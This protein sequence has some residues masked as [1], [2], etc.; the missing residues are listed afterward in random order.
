M[1]SLS[2]SQDIS[3][4]CAAPS[5][6]S[7]VRPPCDNEQVR[8]PHDTSDCSGTFRQRPIMRSAKRFLQ[9]RTAHFPIPSRPDKVRT[10]ST[11]RQ[12]ACGSNCADQDL[13]LVLTLSPNRASANLD[14]ARRTAPRPHH[15]HPEPGASTMC[16]SSLVAV[17][18]RS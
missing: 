5:S 6:C 1:M 8:Q 14:K 15:R 7:E 11:T 12:T 18:P 3:H 16:G 17:P 9:G 2:S 10:K 4:N 13:L